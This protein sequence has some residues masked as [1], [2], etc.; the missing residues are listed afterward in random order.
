MALEQVQVALALGGNQGDVPGAFE[1]AQRGLEKAGL[2]NARRS[3]LYRTSPV[4]CVPGTE[5]FTNAALS[6]I[7]PNSLDDLL[8][9]CKSL[10][11]EAGRPL[12]H[13]KFSSRPLDL[14][15]IFFGEL[16]YARPGLTIPHPE[17]AKRLFV[18]V[19]LSEIAPDLPFPGLNRTVSEQ[20]C[21]VQLHGGTPSAVFKL[22]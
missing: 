7:W 17:A 21:F 5:D 22:V 16:L 20:L 15:I 2:A 14:D 19:P 11:T 1:T 13:L 9:T 18:L 6:G 4:G 12:N 3:S 8:K 10:E